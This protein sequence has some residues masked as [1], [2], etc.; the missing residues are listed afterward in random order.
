M[1]NG[2]KTQLL[3]LNIN[4]TWYKEGLYFKCSQ[5]S[6]CCSGFPG[7]VWIS[8]EEIEQIHKFLKISKNDFL[9]N[10]TRQVYGKISL[11]EDPINYDCCFLKN[12]KCTIY[13]IRPHQCK[14]YPFWESNLSD[15]KSWQGLKKQCPGIDQ[16]DFFS[17]EDIQKKIIS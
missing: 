13:P 9:K 15:K 4:M 14:S 10:Y 16:G 2:K 1:I 6:N 5:C 11:I 17:L 3:K 12:K 7:F 8:Q